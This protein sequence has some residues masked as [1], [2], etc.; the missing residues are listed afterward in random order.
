MPSRPAPEQAS[1]APWLPLPRP[2][3]HSAYRPTTALDGIRLP[4]PPP[5][6]A[7]HTTAAILMLTSTRGIPGME[8]ACAHFPTTHCRM[9]AW[10]TARTVAARRG[11][12]SPPTTLPAPGQPRPSRPHRLVAILMVSHPLGRPPPPGTTQPEARPRRPTNW[13]PPKPHPGR[14]STR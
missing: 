14:G 12:W 11:P 7:S 6:W 8:S 9:P 13:I 4:R 3:E 1:R 10:V 5:T 2:R